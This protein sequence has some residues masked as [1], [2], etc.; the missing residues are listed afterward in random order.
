M[1]QTKATSSASPYCLSSKK[2]IERKLL[3]PEPLAMAKRIQYESIFD[4]LPFCWMPS[5][6]SLCLTYLSHLLGY[7]NTIAP[8]ATAK[9]ES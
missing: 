8:S 1:M 2:T 3:S 7:Q 9:L 6:H 4:L 5:T